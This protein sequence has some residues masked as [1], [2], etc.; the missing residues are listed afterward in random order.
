M[1]HTARQVTTPNNDTLYSSA[2]LDLSNGPVSVDIPT[3]SDR[4]FSVAF[5]DCFTDHFAYVGTRATGGRG[6]RF[7]IAPPGWR[8]AAGEATIIRSPAT[9]VWMLARVLVASA[10]DLPSAVA[11]QTQIAIAEAPPPHPPLVRPTDASD[12]AN[13]LD[14][15]NEMLARNARAPQTTRAAQHLAHWGIRPGERGA[16]ATL[17]KPQQAE[18]SATALKVLSELRQ[19]G[20]AAGGQKVAGWRYPPAGVGGAA[21]SDEVRAMV[22]LSGLGALEQQEA[23]YIRCEEDETGAPL[24]GASAYELTIPA[25]VPAAAFWSLTMYQIESDGRLFFVNNALGRFALGDRTPALV[26]RDD[27]SVRILIRSSD[28]QD[29]G[30]NWLPAPPG[31]FALVFRAYLP[32]KALLSGTW[33]LPAVK[34]ARA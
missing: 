22:A 23:T 19:G 16:F 7:L 31:A 30:A 6:G 25:A 11:E 29:S 10:A 3:M 9:D 21:A 27:G 20:F 2:R 14:V 34:P 28:P 5:M 4:Y 15:V 32:E 1:D 33:R 13:L 8:G 26:R 12:V 17:P 18:W 24:T